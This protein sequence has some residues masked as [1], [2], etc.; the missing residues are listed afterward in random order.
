MAAE[1]VVAQHAAVLVLAPYAG[2]SCDGAEG[3]HLERLAPMH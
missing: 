2:C 3:G 1:D